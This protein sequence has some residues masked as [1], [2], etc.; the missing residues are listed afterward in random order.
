MSLPMTQGSLGLCLSLAYP[1]SEPFCLAPCGSLGTTSAHWPWLGKGWD[2]IQGSEIVRTLCSLSYHIE[3]EAKGKAQPTICYD[4]PGA[5]AISI[6]A[7]W[8]QRRAKPTEDHEGV[9][10]TC[11]DVW[12]H[13]RLSIL[14][15]VSTGV[16]SGSC[17]AFLLSG[18][19]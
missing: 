1:V 5:W 15:L 7:T 19:Q 2:E 13:I 3:G 10:R 6:L 12:D 18:T 9:S 17:S 4:A 14:W 11:F 16:E 8:S